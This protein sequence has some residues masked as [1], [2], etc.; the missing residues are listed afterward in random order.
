MVAKVETDGRG[1]SLQGQLVGRA[2]RPEDAALPLHLPMLR[3]ACDGSGSCCSQYLQ[4]PATAED[5]DRIVEVVGPVWRGRPTLDLFRPA[6]PP[7][8]PEM[9]NIAEMG[10]R[11][12]FQQDDG[13][14]AVHAA[15]GPMAKPQPC[16]AY[17]AVLTVCGDEWHAS[18]RTECACLARSAMTGVPL[19]ADPEPWVLLRSMLVRV[20]SVPETVCVEGDRRIDRADYVT[21]MRNALARMTTT[22]EPLAALREAG[23]ELGLSADLPPPSRWLRELAT[24]AATKRAEAAERDPT[25]GYRVAIEW[26]ARIAAALA[27]GADSAPGWSRGRAQHHARMLASVATAHLHGHG[28]LQARTLQDGFEQLV[29]LLWLA[30]ASEALEPARQ[31]DPRFESVTTWVFLFGHVLD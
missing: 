7:A 2:V 23:A 8:P 6:P 17:P 5:R 26:G 14:C 16:L 27:D 11:C 12:A 13:L 18:L 1:G 3:A 9:L 10:G 31:A 15:A 30:T 20:W 25:S 19:S 21:W 28:L 24:A 29:R 22:F 4:V